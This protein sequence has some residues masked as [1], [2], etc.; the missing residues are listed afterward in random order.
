MKKK[1]TKK[2][3]KTS[4]SSPNRNQVLL[5]HIQLQ[6][7]QTSPPK[8][9]SEVKSLLGM[10][11]Y[12]SRFISNYATITAPLRLLTR[13][14]TPWKREQEEQRA[15]AELKEVLVGDQ[16][17]SYF[18]PKKKT[19]IIVDASPVGLGG[20]LLQEGKVLSYAS[21]ALSDIESR[22]SQ[23]EREMLAVV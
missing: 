19:E 1:K 7:H 14:D 16:V 13:Q 2:T 4:V 10:T 23:T 17:T 5:A 22:Y 15:L 3:T 20:L 12:V 11:Q 6:W 8:N 9:P 18:D 21:R